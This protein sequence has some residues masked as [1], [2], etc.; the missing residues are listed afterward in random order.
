MTFDTRQSVV[1]EKSIETHEVTFHIPSWL[2][3]KEFGRLF[4]RN[5]KVVDKN[6]FCFVEPSMQFRSACQICSPLVYGFISNDVFF[7]SR[8]NV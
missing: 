1:N 2:A 8:R 5:K 3:K 7:G 4:F 6:F